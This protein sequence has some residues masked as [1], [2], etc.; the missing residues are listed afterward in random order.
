MGRLIHAPVA[1]A[2]LGDGAITGVR[3][4]RDHVLYSR[5]G[6]AIPAWLLLILQHPSGVFPD[7]VNR[8]RDHLRNKKTPWNELH[9]RLERLLGFNCPAIF[10]PETGPLTANPR[11]EQI[12]DRTQTL[13]EDPNSLSPHPIKSSEG[14]SW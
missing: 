10:S 11:T 8:F 9:R 4:G 6:S 14:C 13:M 3:V 12:P 2:Q 7:L 5:V 1:V